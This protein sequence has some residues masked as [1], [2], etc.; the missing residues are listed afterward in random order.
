[1]KKANETRTRGR[2]GAASESPPSRKDEI[3]AAGYRVV[4]RL[5]H[6]NLTF[7]NVAEEANVPLGSTTYY[8]ADKTDLL[9]AILLY[10]KERTEARYDRILRDLRNGAPIVDTVATMVDEMTSREHGWLVRDYELFLSGFDDE[11]LSDVCRDWTLS[12][13]RALAPFLPENIRETLPLLLE[14]IFLVSTKTG[15]QF[16][17][18]TVRSLMQ[19][20][21]GQA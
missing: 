3:I 8:F 17:A 7:R 12:S 11:A 21:F 16:P 10:G 2:Q 19:P 4:Q 20:L 18:E 5:G 14:G 9:R 15:R 6:K 1:M 13:Q